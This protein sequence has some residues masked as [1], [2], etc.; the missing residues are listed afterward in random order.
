M[1][2]IQ[3]I[4]KL[5]SYTLEYSYLLLPF[6]FL[7]SKAKKSSLTIVLC[8][9]G[10]VFFFF[11]HYYYDIPRSLLKVKQA[12]YTLLEYSFF[13]FIVWQSIQ[14]KKIRTVIVV[15]SF[16]FFIFQSLYFF[17]FKLQ[18]I[19]SI[20]IGVET[21]IL[22]LF[23]FLYFQQYFKTNLTNNIYEYSSFWLVV[24]ILIYL[25]SSFF[26]NILANHVTPQQFADY[27]HFTYIPEIIKN[28]LFGLVIIGYPFKQINSVKTKSTDI[29]N[30]DMI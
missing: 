29:P 2:K 6:L 15:F 18:K 12:F 22:F 8:S 28:L 27:W 7:I 30:L 11:L 24:G 20:P 4:E 19:D 14:N 3:I 10:L 16:L 25:G 21:I 9:Y 1:V 23:A 13:A 5:F 26:F 17:F